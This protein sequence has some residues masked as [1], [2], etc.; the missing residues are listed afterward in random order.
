M[1]SE[2]GRKLRRDGGHRP[3]RAAVEYSPPGLGSRTAAGPRP[4]RGGER[5]DLAAR[6]VGGGKAELLV[7][8][9]Y[10]VSAKTLY[11]DTDA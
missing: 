9:S 10:F 7:H 2:R 5:A 4:A 1:G 11:L 3:P 6:L 8:P